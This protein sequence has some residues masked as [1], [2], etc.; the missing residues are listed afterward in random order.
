M[1]PRCPS[2]SWASV[3]VAK[4]EEQFVAERA[5]EYRGIE[6]STDLFRHDVRLGRLSVRK[7][8]RLPRIRIGEFPLVEGD[9]ATGQRRLIVGAADECTGRH[10]QPVGSIGA[11]AGG[12]DG[13]TILQRNAD[14]ARRLPA[15][16]GASH[17]QLVADSDLPAG[18][19]GMPPSR[20]PAPAD[21]LN[22]RVGNARDRRADCRSNQSLP[23][24]PLSAGIAP[25][26][27]RRV[28]DG[29]HGRVMFQLRAREHGTVVQETP[30]SF[31]VFPVEPRQVVSPEL[32]HGDEQHEL[33]I[34]SWRRGSLRREGGW[35]PRRGE[36]DQDDN[37][38]E[39]LRQNKLQNRALLFEGA[40]RRRYLEGYARVA[41]LGTSGASCASNVQD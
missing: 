37:N 4:R 38:Q 27:H 1:T 32:V 29:G 22:R 25:R 5:A 26:K 2:F 14:D 16:P 30:E 6:W 31:L 21:D 15:R 36:S 3:S 7:R 11:S 10:V 13:G 20:R 34:G 19:W 35:A 39:T 41:G 23:M 12:Q 17:L 40:T 24:I 33:D 8:P 9:A 18:A 28:P